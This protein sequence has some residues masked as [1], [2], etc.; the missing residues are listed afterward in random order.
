MKN[1]MTKI[2][3]Y[4]IPLAAVSAVFATIVIVVVATK[5]PKE[6]ATWDYGEHADKVCPTLGTLPTPYVSKLQPPFDAALRQAMSDLVTAAG[7]PLFVEASSTQALSPLTLQIVPAPK[8]YSDSGQ[9]CEPLKIEESALLAA[10]TMAWFETKRTGDGALLSATIFVCT[11]KI[12]AAQTLRSATAKAV[13][14]LGS[15]AILTH[16]LLHVYLG[17]RH[18]RYKCGL[19]CQN[20]VI[21]GLGVQTTLLLK[22]TISRCQ[23]ASKEVAP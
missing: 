19:F 3:P 10:G 18:P 16:E 9:P 6:A 21:P 20:P 7:Q 22:Q 5:A 17:P 4:F 1:F 23:R 14:Q 13:R 12:T 15:V 11:D 8:L 2:L